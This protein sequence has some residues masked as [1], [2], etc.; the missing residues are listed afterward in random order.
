[1]KK[2]IVFLLVLILLLCVNLNAFSSDNQGFYVDAKLKNKIIVL[3]N[4]DK[5]YVDG[6]FDKIDISNSSVTPVIVEGRTLLPVRFFV[7]NFGGNVE[8]DGSS[9]K[10]HISID[11]NELTMYVGNNRVYLNNTEREIDV[12]PQI[13]S[14]RTYLPLRF[15]AEEVLS[16]DILY[17]KG[18]VSVSDKNSNLSEI[19]DIELLDRLILDLNQKLGNTA[20]N[21]RQWGVVAEDNDG[22]IFYVEQNRIKMQDR[23]Y[24]MD[25]NGNNKKLLLT[26]E[27]IYGLNLV[28]DWIYFLKDFGDK[29]FHQSYAI[30][31]IKKNGTNLEKVT[32][33]LKEEARYMLV[34]D[35]WI[36][37]DDWNDNDRVLKRI[38][39]DGKNEIKISNE[40]S[41]WSFCVEGNNLYFASTYNNRPYVWTDLNGSKEINPLLPKLFSVDTPLT[42]NGVVYYVHESPRFVFNIMAYDLRTMTKN[43]VLGGLEEASEFNIYEDRIYYSQGLKLYSV[44]LDGTDNKLIREFSADKSAIDSAIGGIYVTKS[45]IAVEVSHWPSR[46]SNPNMQLIFINK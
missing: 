34:V 35:N 39:L 1:M 45:K 43:V 14:D 11:N 46:H 40:A 33:K 19:E 4:S 26:S 27:I 7:E 41:P 20:G 12:P 22:T 5:C 25:A 23:L 28:G 8:W 15:L 17:Y 3:I 9:K 29:Q 44:K 10:I 31:R 38:D 37:F 42:H 13:I 16:K 32:N 18:L 30:Y 6:F 24:R 21:I 2:G 36:Y